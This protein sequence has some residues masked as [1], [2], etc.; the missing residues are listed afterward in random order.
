MW[1]CQIVFL[2]GLI[3]RLRNSFTYLLTY[4]MTETPVD[5]IFNDNSSKH[6][7][8][9]RWLVLSQVHTNIKQRFVFN[10]HIYSIE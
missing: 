2:D 8:I 7:S 1:F 3:W 9:A 4:L 5:R 10:K 6:F